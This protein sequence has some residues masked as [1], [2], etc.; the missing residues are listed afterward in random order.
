MITG[1]VNPYREAVIPLSLQDACGQE[2]EIEFIIDTGFTGEM[3][4]TPHHIRTLGLTLLGTGRAVLANGSI[5]TFDYY[6]ATALWDGQARVVS[7]ESA[8]TSPLIGMRLLQGY[9][10]HLHIV[11]GG[12]VTLT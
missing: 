8:N 3:T 2:Q 1:R 9:H 6:E 7:A 12:K 11:D 4:L 10:L 5:D